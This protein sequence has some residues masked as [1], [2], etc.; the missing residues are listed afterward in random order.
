MPRFSTAISFTAAIRRAMSARVKPSGKTM[1]RIGFGGSVS[2]DALGPADAEPPPSKTSA[3][4]RTY[5]IPTI[6]PSPTSTPRSA[7][8]LA[9]RFRR[10]TLLTLGGCSP[11]TAGS[12]RGGVR[13]QRRPPARVLSEPGG[14]R[15]GEALVEALDRE[16]GRGAEALDEALGLLGLRPPLAAER[17]RKPDDDR[18]RRPPRG[19]PRGR[20]RD[21][22]PSPPARR[23]RAAGPRYRWGRRRRRRSAPTRSRGR[24]PSPP[25][26]SSR[27]ACRQP[28]SS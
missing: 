24:A 20:A 9:P 16:L 14:Q 13:R 5:P 12:S 18:A 23:P 2:V 22:P 28:R 7:A 8:S 11:S 27:R 17:E 6:R 10:C 21:R 1:R 3:W 19:R 26:D 15:G 25:G 4:A